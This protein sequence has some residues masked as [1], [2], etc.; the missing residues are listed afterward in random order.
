MNGWSNESSVAHHDRIESHSIIERCDG[1]EYVQYQR[2]DLNEI[3]HYLC[4]PNRNAIANTEAL[5]VSDRENI[6]TE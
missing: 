1:I 4:N 6:G 2:D 5:R 3:R